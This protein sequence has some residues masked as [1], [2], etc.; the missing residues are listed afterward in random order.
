MTK[1]ENMNQTGKHQLSGVTIIVAL[2][3]LLSGTKEAFM[4]ALKKNSQKL[5]W[6]VLS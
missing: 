5:S 3:Q 1:K 4:F 2:S 6:M